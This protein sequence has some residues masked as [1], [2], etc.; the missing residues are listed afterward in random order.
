MHYSEDVTLL[1]TLIFCGLLCFLSFKLFWRNGKLPPG[2]TPLPVIGNILQLGGGNMTTSLLKLREKYGDVFTVYM[3]SRPIVVVTGYKAIKE[4]Y[5]DQ[6]EDFLARGDFFTLDAFYKNYGVVF[7]SDVDRWRELRRFSLT[8]MRDFGMGKKRLEDQIQEEAQ[9]LVTELK[10]TKESY[11]DPRLMFNTVSSNV[12]HSI[13]FGNRHNYDD[14]EH[15]NMLNCMYEC[16]FIVCSIWGQ[17]TEMFPGIMP[18]IPG[19]HQKM[20]SNMEELMSYAREKVEKSRK[21]LDPNNPRDY[22]DVFLIKMEKVKSNTKNE[23]NLENLVNS[24]IQIFMAGV[25]TTGSTLTYAVLLL[26]KYPEVLEKVHKEIEHVIGHE[27]CPKVEDRKQMPFTEAVVHEIQR[28]I[29]LLPLGVPRKTTRDVEFR[30]Y[31]LPKNTNVYPILSSVLKNPDYFLYPNEFNPQNF[32]DENGE[33]KRNDAFIPLSLGKRNC[34]GEALVRM[35]IFIF[36]TVI[37]QNFRLQS[38]VPREDLDITPNVSGFG[39]IPKLFKMSF[40]PL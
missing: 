36:L 27:R 40:I 13:I 32:L 24:T 37:V 9:C 2:P 4:V 15:L 18:F 33:F 25:E 8:V 11:F 19:Y 35:E 12:I 21:T 30:G 5:V 28:F 14:V 20:T 29:D 6:A 34:L 39:N 16:F 7:T 38:E 22:V 17:L 1:L 10:K 23:F 31:L 26:M 3:G